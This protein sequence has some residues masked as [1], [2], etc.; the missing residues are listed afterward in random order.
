MGDPSDPKTFVGPVI[1]EA[2]IQKAK[3]YIE[4][5]KKE[6]RLLTGG[7]F[8]LEKGYFLEPTVFGDVSPKATI[9]Q[10]EIFGPVLTLYVYDD[11]K[12][13]IGKFRNEPKV[14]NAM[15]AFSIFGSP[16]LKFAFLMLPKTSKFMK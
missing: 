15:F 12:Y 5:G 7:N 2:A 16:P 3:K 6:G 13:E 4:I 10:E 11:N 8:H 14:K 1:S 9:A